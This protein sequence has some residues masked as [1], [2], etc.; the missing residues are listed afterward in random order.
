LCRLFRHVS[1]SPASASRA[2]RALWL[3]AASSISA[4]F[5]ERPF[6]SHQLQMQDFGRCRLARLAGTF[7][8]AHYLF[9]APKPSV[10]VGWKAI[11]WRT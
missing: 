10:R 2:K 11:T 4:F 3:P 8:R 6:R 5:S 9:Q 7:A 1:G